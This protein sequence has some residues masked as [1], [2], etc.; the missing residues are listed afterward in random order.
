MKRTLHFIGFKGDEYHSAVKIWGKPGM[1]HIGYDI[2]ALTEIG[3]DDIVI[4][5]K[6]E[7]TQA[8]NTK[9][10]FPDIIEKTC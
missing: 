3:E 1:V 5:A 9:F 6:G 4:F 7:W 2:R 10:N 8:P